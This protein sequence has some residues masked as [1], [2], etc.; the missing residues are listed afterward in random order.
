MLG[1]DLGTTRSKVAYID[2]AG[3]P[4]IILN[5]RGEPYTP[6]A[7]LIPS[8]GEPL[9]GADAIEQGYSDSSRCL[10]NF[11]LKLGSTENLMNNGQLVTAVDAAALFLGF[12][13]K[14]AEKHLGMEVNYC[15]VTCPANFRDD[16]KQALLEACKQAGLNVQTLVHEPTAAGFAYAL[17]KGGERKFMVYDFGGGTFDVSIQLVQGDQITTLATEGIPKLGG[18]HLDECIKKRILGEIQ[19]KY[20]A[21]PTFE[22]D[23]LFHLDLDQKAERAKIS[24]NNREKVPVVVP[25]N[26]HQVVLEISRKD[27]HADID[28]LVNQTL[29]S[30]HKALASANLNI[31][32]IDHLVMVGGTSRI[33]HIQDKVADNTGLYPKT[34]VDPDKAVAY[35]A[36]FVSISEMAKKGK[37]ATL[38][39]QVIPSPEIFVRDVTAHAVGCCVV[40]TSGPNKRLTNA[41]IIQKNTAVPCR[42]SDQFCLE[43]EDQVEARIEILQGEPDAERDECLLIG[44]LALTNLPKETTRT[45]RI[46]V[47]YMID[48]NGMVTATAT[49]KVSG[50]QQTVSVDYNK[51]IKPKDKPAAV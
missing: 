11:K 41:V 26:G 23:S 14:M 20:G 24:L 33:R 8:S 4:I 7:V 15:V 32:Q 29:E 35:G 27:F 37:T 3:K 47:E 9:F 46:M 5:D 28:P 18:I 2:P 12:L 13:K 34:D 44:E 50:Q 25:C 16:A 10:R 30:V 39:G 22:Q 31:Q 36:A 51:G 49:D 21:V 38:R 45:A 48:A 6:T 17:Q 43:H 40:N 19:A 42:R 1:I